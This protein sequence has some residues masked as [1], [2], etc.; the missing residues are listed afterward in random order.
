LVALIVVDSSVYNS[1]MSGWTIGVKSSYAIIA[2]MV[3]VMTVVLIT[4]ALIIVVSIT[5]ASMITL[6]IVPD[7]SA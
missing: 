7:R 4:L 2:L 1:G 5:I 3:V 6:I